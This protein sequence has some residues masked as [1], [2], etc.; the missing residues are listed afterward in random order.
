MPPPNQNRVKGSFESF[1]RK[2]INS[3][4]GPS[5][6]GG[7]K[8]RHYKLFKCRFQ[9]ETYTRLKDRSLVKCMAKLRCSNHNLR[10]ETGRRDNTHPELRYCRVCNTQEVEDEHHF[11]VEC[12]TYDQ[13]RKK[14][15]ETAENEVK[16]FITVNPKQKFIYLLSTENIKLVQEIAKYAR[17]AFES[18]NNS[19]HNGP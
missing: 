6:S 4:V 9:A 7:N 2:R 10:I 14:L 5:K 17:D 19:L 15:L 1:W 16:S 3:S 18:R 13:H 8:L 11:L 12:R